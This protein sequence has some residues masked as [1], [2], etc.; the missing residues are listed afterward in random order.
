MVFLI[1]CFLVFGLLGRF[2]AL[3]VFDLISG[4]REKNSSY[5]DKSI[6]HHYYD[7]RQIHLNSDIITAN[8]DEIPIDID[9]PS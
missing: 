8:R 7:N 5:T 2:V 9:K 4:S 3:T 6:H 1:I